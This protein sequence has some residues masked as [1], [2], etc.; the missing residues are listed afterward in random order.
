MKLVN[1]V[2]EAIAE[3]Y[4]VQW[5][6]RRQT[7]NYTVAVFALSIGVAVFFAAMDWGLSNLLDLLIK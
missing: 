3:L 7:I 6:T 2:K 4:K 1:Y 5:L